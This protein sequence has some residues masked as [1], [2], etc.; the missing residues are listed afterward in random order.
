M[1]NEGIPPSATVQSR[2]PVEVWENVIDMLYSVLL[3]DQIEHSR[4]LH[5][6]ALVCR[7]W[8]V[9]SQRNLFYAVVLKDIATLRKFSAVLDDAPHLRDYVREVALVAR[10]LHTTA[11]PLSLFPIILHSKLPILE[12]FSIKCVTDVEDRYPSAF[13][14]D[15]TTEPLKY[16]PLHPRFPIFLSAFTAITRLFVISVTFRHLNDLLG[17]VNALPALRYLSCGSILCRTLGPLPMYAKLQPD[18]NHPRA[19]LFAPNLEELLLVCVV[20]YARYTCNTS[21]PVPNGRALCR[22][23]DNSM[24]ASPQEVNSQHAL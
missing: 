1:D 7:A 23:N 2:F 9:R 21:C 15:P 24:W 6:C 12:E 17:T 5:S 4:T 10:T 20:Q 3:P 19:R 14:R 8:R 11:S 13:T 18:T 16:L 22:G